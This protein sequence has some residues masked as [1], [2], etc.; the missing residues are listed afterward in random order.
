[1]D[2]TSFH[3]TR[4]LQELV[5]HHL[6]AN[7]TDSQIQKMVQYFMRI[8]GSRIQSNYQVADSDHLKQQLLK[9]SKE[10]V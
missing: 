9:K 2:K 6:P 7:A 4:Q 3:V 5:A 1:M 8:L 10:W